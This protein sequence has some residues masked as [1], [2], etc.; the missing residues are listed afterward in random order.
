MMRRVDNTGFENFIDGERAQ[1][2]SL[3]R[4]KCPR[5]ESE[6]VLLITNVYTSNNSLYCNNCEYEA[7]GA[8]WERKNIYIQSER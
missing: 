2:E 7:R 4:I 1:W 6:N 5:C 3:P 8:R